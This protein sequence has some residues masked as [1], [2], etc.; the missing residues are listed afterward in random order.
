MKFCNIYHTLGTQDFNL[1]IK[2]EGMKLRIN[3]QNIKLQ[4]II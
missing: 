3:L 4:I 1:L 2:F